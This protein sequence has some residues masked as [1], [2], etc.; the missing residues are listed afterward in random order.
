MAEI[1]DSMDYKIYEIQK[2]TM[3]GV[4][5]CLYKVRGGGRYLGCY[6]KVGPHTGSHAC[7]NHFLGNHALTIEASEIEK[8][9]DMWADDALRG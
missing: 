4:A 8:R 6:F 5:G 2:C 3:G 9:L 7:M 1:R